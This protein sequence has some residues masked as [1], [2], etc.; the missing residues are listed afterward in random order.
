MDSPAVGTAGRGESAESR[1]G[2]VQGGRSPERAESAERGEILS[3]RLLVYVEEQA[4]QSA[5]V[6]RW[7]S[8]VTLV[9]KN[10]PASAGNVRDASSILGL[11]RCLGGGHG[12]PL[13]YSYLENPMDRR[14]WQ[15]TVHGVIKSRTR[16][17]D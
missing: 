10:L 13:Q 7:A 4:L 1:G 5:A 16:L 15:A 2:G 3:F 8:Q 11:G 14:A 17:S 12:H 6:D 9:V